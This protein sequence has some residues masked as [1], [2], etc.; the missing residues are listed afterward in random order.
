MVSRMHFGPA[1][2]CSLIRSPRS[3]DEIAKHACQILEF[4]ESVGLRLTRGL[5]QSFG[6]EIGNDLRVSMKRLAPILVGKN[7]FERE[8]W[9]HATGIRIFNRIA[10]K[11]FP[12]WHEAFRHTKQSLCFPPLPCGTIHP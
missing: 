7:L 4:I 6:F 12:N 1:H 3:L 9:A 11:Q 8:T 2:H 5:R 10:D